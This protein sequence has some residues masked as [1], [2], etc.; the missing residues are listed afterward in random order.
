[1]ALKAKFPSAT[2]PTGKWGKRRKNMA[3]FLELNSDNVVIQ[4]IAIND[5]VIGDK[6]F[7]ESEEIGVAFCKSLYGEQTN[8]KQTSPDGL[9]RKRYAGLGY[10]YDARLDAFIPPKPYNSW[11]L[12]PVE[13][14]WQA[15]IEA[16]VDNKSYAWDEDSMSWKE[17]PYS[18]N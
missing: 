12:N 6:V 14:V 16:P 9:F 7:P 10:S 11:V 8:W 15:P 2:C 13:C 18:G 4:A 17:I 5:D 3:A 1:M